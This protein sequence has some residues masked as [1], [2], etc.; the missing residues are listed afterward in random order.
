MQN[1]LEA[2]NL[3]VTDHLGDLGT[4]GRIIS[5]LLLKEYAR[6]FIGLL[7][8]RIGISDTYKHGNS[9]IN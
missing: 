2:D 4:E 3:K 1:G 6:A 5:K 8:L 7:W 9:L